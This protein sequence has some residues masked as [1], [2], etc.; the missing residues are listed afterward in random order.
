MVENAKQSKAKLDKEKQ[1]KARQSAPL[2]LSLC[3]APLLSLL[4]SLFILLRDRVQ[5][6]WGRG[7]RVH[8]GAR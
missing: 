5:V 1:S 8:G 7:S 3:P 6:R 4:S 2:S